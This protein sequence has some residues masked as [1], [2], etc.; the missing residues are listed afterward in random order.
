[1]IL[2]INAKLCQRIVA[3]NMNRYHSSAASISTP[4]KKKNCREK[5][6]PGENLSRF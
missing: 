5:R 1:M 4:P 2:F 6:I 3:G